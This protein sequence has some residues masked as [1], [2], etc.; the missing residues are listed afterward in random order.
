MWAHS[1]AFRRKEPLN[2]PLDRTPF[3]IFPPFYFQNNHHKHSKSRDLSQQY[4]YNN[5][6]PADDS[7]APYFD[8]T[9]GDTKGSQAQEVEEPIWKSW[10]PTH[11]DYVDEDDQLFGEELQDD[12][13]RPTVK[14]TPTPYG[15][16]GWCRMQVDIYCNNMLLNKL[17]NHYHF[18]TIIYLV[19]YSFLL[20]I[21]LTGSGWRFG[22][23][24]FGVSIW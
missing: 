20:L 21:S 9:L 19:W 12:L 3:S 1:G 10:G 23:G 2:A 11:E 16:F 17:T 5:N 24:I 15:E 7:N 4:D 22:F 8:Q 14:H 13:Q 18:F 6:D